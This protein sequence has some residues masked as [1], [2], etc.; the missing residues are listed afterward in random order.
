MYFTLLWTLL[1]GHAIADFA[2]QS[3][4][5]A[6][7]KNRNRP[8][9]LSI[10]PPGQV[11]QPSWFYWLTAH[12]LIHGAAVA[13]LTQNCLYGMLETA[14]HWLIDFGKCDNWYGIHTDQALHVLCKVAWVY[15]W[16]HGIGGNAI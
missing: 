7:G 13:F 5:M 15:L 9:D 14:A 8:M 4:A 11:Y 1:T 6:K 3:D 10:V 16:T 12:A 2:L